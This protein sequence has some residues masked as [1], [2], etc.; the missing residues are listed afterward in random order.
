MGNSGRGDDEFVYLTEELPRHQVTLSAYQI[1]KYEVNNGQYCEVLNWAKGRGYLENSGGGPYSGG[2]V[3]KNGQ[4]LL[5][6]NDA[7]CQISYSSGSHMKAQSGQSLSSQPTESWTSFA[8][9]SMP[10]S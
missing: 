6:I 1:G 10:P 8:A 2:N 5:K 3:Y 7:E 4:M 9:T